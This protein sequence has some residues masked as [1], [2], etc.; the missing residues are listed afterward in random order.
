MS[1]AAARLLRGAAAGAVLLGGVGVPY[2]ALACAVCTAGREEANRDAFVAT[3][4]FL[5]LLPLFTVGA[6]VWW[7][8]RRGVA[9]GRSQRDP[10]F[11]A[12]TAA[13]ETGSRAVAARRRVRAT[14]NSPV[15]TSIAAAGA[16]RTLRRGPAV[17]AAPRGAS[18]VSPGRVGSPPRR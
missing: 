8:S 11:E 18:A 16:V 2:T 14:H 12:E 7:F 15:V 5:T 4:V 6:A 3:A 1:R 10:A 9:A 13:A 17:P